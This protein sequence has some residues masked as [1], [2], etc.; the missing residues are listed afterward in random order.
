M[1]IALNSNWFL[2]KK[3]IATTALVIVSTSLIWFFVSKQEPIP[4]IVSGQ[5][6]SPIQAP[7]REEWFCDHISNSC[8]RQNSRVAIV[9]PFHNFQS[10]LDNVK[11]W[12]RSDTAPCDTSDLRNP[13]F[14]DLVFSCDFN[15]SCP[16][17]EPLRNA[18]MNGLH[19]CFKNVIFQV[20]GIPDAGHDVGS[21]LHFLALLSRL[22]QTY[23]YFFLMEGDT[24]PI[25]ENWA[26]QIFLESACGEDFWMKGSHDRN[27]GFEGARDWG[28]H[29]NGNALY[30]I[31]DQYLLKLMYDLI[32]AGDFYDMLL[33]GWVRSPHNYLITRNI[34]H[35]Y[36]FSGFVQNRFHYGPDAE[37]VVST[38]R[39][40]YP[41]TYF[42]HGQVFRED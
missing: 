15:A 29:I 3:W 32:N 27:S 14:V 39:R 17:F 4:V 2:Q 20:E 40:E 11:R 8:P 6:T 19:K 41:Y 1:M 36:R 18:V 5:N 13:P 31:R 12:K 24:H 42:V 7:T 16:D 28:W 21:K 33:G 38:M 10:I 26:N 23:D 37:W 22:N 34:L 35:L 9:M 30:N 25:R